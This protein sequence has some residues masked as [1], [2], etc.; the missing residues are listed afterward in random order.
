MVNLLKQL[1]EASRRQDGLAVAKLL[2]I[3]RLDLEN[4]AN[5]TNEA[6]VERDIKRYLNDETW[7][8]IAIAYWRVAVQ[9]AKIQDL[10]SAY[11]A[12]KDLL[13]ASNRAAEKMDNW[14]LPVLF[15]IAKELRY[16]SILV[17]NL[18]FFSANVSKYPD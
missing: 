14:I 15:L 2:S 8:S 4:F 3:T 17:C 11:G 12:Q 5:F 16:L 7:A 13:V 10:Q 6:T 9:V 1:G 18:F